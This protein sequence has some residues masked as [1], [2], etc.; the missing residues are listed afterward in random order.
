MPK[1]LHSASL[2]VSR[3][4]FRFLSIFSFFLQVFTF[5]KKNLSCDLVPQQCCL[6]KFPKN[7]GKKGKKVIKVHHDANTLCCA[8][9]QEVFALSEGFQEVFCAWKSCKKQ[10]DHEGKR[11]FLLGCS[12][13]R[14][15][16][17]RRGFGVCRTGREKSC[18]DGR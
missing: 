2:P 10:L 12:V 17:Q 1:C 8:S 16:R 9:L 15:W 3:S 4:H 5:W 13:R 6:G 18:S 7:G 11:D 14:C